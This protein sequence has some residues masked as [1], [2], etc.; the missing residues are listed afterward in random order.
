MRRL[1]LGLLGALLLAAP[2]AV[3]AQSLYGPG[4]LFLHPTASMPPKGRITP[5]FL[6]LPQHD[7][8]ARSTRVW[9]STS[10]DYGLT[11][12]L[13]IGATY[14]KVTGWERDGS[15]GGFV[16]YRLMRESLTQPA[17]AIG[18]TQLGGGDV[19]TRSGFLAF[20][21][22]FGL[23]KRRLLV[24]HLGVQYVD[25]ADGLAKHEF[26]PY[27]GLELGLTSRLTFI[28]EARPRGN[29][30]F[31]TPLALTLSYKV[32]K[33]W[34]LAATWANNGRSDEPRFGFGAGLSLGSR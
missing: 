2:A 6:L 25:E 21:K 17:I 15:A 7:P 14:L 8:V 33:N 9:L 10:V 30:E 5:G 28:A 22:Q 32:S 16:K 4:G 34:H 26:E 19:N 29:Q 27:A 12:D 23:G 1:L 24:A 11:D 31:G 3:S 18:Y 20:R 13:E